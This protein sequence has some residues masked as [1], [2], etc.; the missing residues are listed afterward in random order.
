[1]NHSMRLTIFNEFVSLK[2]LSVAETRFASVL[3][4]LKRFELVESG[5]RTMVI[6]GKWT[7]YREVGGT[8]LIIF[9]L[10]LHPY[11]TWFELVIQ[12]HLVFIWCMTCGKQWLKR[13]RRQYIDMKESIMRNHPPFIMCYTKFLLIVG[14]RLIPHSIIWHIPWTQGTIL[15]CHM[16]LFLF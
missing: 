3:V 2:L 12:T 11:I 9:F 15:A 10:S 4:M 8:R 13:W 1:M 7:C 16:F 6:S 14:S 5:V